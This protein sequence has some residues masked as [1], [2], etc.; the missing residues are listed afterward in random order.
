MT[1]CSSS[2]S[3]SDLLLL[4]NFCSDLLLCLEHYFVAVFLLFKIIAVLR[5]LFCC[6]SFISGSN[7]LLW[8]EHSLVA[9]V[10]LF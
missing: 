5:G 6:S 9:V 1:C 8:F 4:F 2:S 3:G 7:L 10:L